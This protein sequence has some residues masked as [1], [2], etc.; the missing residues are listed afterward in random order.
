M[1]KNFNQ[2]E[3]QKIQVSG[4]EIN[5][6]TISDGNIDAR[7]VSSFGEEWTKFNTFTEKEYFDKNDATYACV[8]R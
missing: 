4:K 8:V 7:T 3:K 6:F 2:L 1:M 5:V